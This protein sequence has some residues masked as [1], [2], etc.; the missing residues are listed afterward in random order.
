GRARSPSST[1]GCRT[2]SAPPGTSPSRS[3]ACSACK[4]NASTSAP[5]P[6]ARQSAPDPEPAV[7]E[8]IATFR[9]R[10]EDPPAGP[11]S[12][13]STEWWGRGRGLDPSEEVLVTGP[14]LTT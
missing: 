13:L 8:S 1:P 3:S 14:L 9:G 7:A 2:G 6:G 4:E 10:C 11:A 5:R 12:R